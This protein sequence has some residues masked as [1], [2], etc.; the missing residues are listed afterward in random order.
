MKKIKKMITEEMANPIVDSLR[1]RVEATRGVFND[2]FREHILAV[3]DY[4]LMSGLRCG[5][6]MAKIAKDARAS[7]TPRVLVKPKAKTGK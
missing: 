4:A 1:E 3:Y 2:A 6:V 7:S 5:V